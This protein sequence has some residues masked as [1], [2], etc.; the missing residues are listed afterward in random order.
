MEMWLL[1]VGNE[2]RFKRITS[3]ACQF[4]NALTHPFIKLSTD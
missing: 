3:L 1:F 4:I 2:P